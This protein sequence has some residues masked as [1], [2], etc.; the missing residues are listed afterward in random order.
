MAGV[1]L[2]YPYKGKTYRTEA[3]FSAAVDADR[4]AG[5]GTRINAGTGGVTNTDVPGSM[6]G[7]N[8]A[9]GGGGQ[10]GQVYVPQTGGG[11]LLTQ[12]GYENQ[13]LQKQAGTIESGQQRAQTEAQ[14]LMQQ[15]EAAS[16]AG[17]MELAARLQQQAEQRRLGYLS[18]IKGSE[19]VVEHWS[20][21][22]GAEGAARTA[23]FARAKEQAGQ[24]AVA[25]LSALRDVIENRGLMGSSVEAAGTGAAIGGAGEAVNGY[26][27]EQLQ[28][29]LARAAQLSDIQY[30]GGIQQRGQN[31]SMIPSLMGLITASG[32]MAY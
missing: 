25:S 18:T 6:G 27:R 13:Q 23:A 21:D 20:M 14:R 8:S 19:P 12:G 10:D 15:A 26:T 32:G 16:K 5:S 31:L 17:Q 29:D 2:G 9:V 7:L 11:P 28:Q 3:E 1:V 22:A 30:K 24:T 4:Q